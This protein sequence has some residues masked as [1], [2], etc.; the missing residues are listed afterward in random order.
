MAATKA[1]AFEGA[2]SGNARQPMGGPLRLRCELGIGRGDP[3]IK[4]FPLQLR[5]H[6]VAT[7]I[8]KIR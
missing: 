5:E 1:A 7:I 8:H 3:L 2:D 4:R 6:L